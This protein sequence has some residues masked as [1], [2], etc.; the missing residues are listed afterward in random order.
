M[1]SPS[2][3]VSLEPSLAG[4]NPSSGCFPSSPHIAFYSFSHLHFL[5]PPLTSTHPLKCPISLLNLSLHSSQIS[6][7]SPPSRVHLSLLGFAAGSKLCPPRS[8]FLP[9]VTRLLSPVACILPPPRLRW[10]LPCPLDSPF[11]PI[12][13]SLYSFSFRLPQCCQG[14]CLRD[15]QPQCRAIGFP[16]KIQPRVF[17]HDPQPGK[18]LNLSERHW[19][20]RAEEGCQADNA[21]VHGGDR[22]EY[23][24]LFG[25]TGEVRPCPPQARCQEF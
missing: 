23:K 10:P 1:T 17:R 5:L 3:S 14:G 13:P 2:S 7:F 18:P 25:H 20:L 15:K 6:L 21:T 4:L 24:L 19:W 11:P 16:D 8:L 9:Q 12:P 22:L